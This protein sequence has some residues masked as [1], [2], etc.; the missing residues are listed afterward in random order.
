MDV[1]ITAFSA[2]G[3]FSV[4]P[5]IE[6][7]EAVARRVGARFKPVEVS[8]AAAEALVDGLADA[9]PE[10]WLMLGVAEEAGVVRV[11]RIARNQAGARVDV[12]GIGRRQ[13]VIDTAAPASVEGRL[14]T[15]IINLPDGAA[16][17][18]NAGDYLCNYLY[19][20]GTMR[21]PT[22]R[23]GFIHVAPTERIEPAR[24]VEIVAAVLHSVL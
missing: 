1:L 14:F 18:D 11:E 15:K 22:T 2:F 5:S 19:L 9:P 12:R 10:V 13:G 23:T 3:R 21:L 7:G 4:N 16:E 24:Q 20:L 6:I 17:S 8:F